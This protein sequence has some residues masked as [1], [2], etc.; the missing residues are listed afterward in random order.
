MLKLN[1]LITDN[2][3]LQ[4]EKEILISGHAQPNVVVII[5]IENNKTVGKTDTEG[6]FLIKLPPQKYGLISKLKVTAATDTLEVAVQ[7]GDVFLFSGQSNIE[8]LMTNE[9]HFSDEKQKLGLEQCGIYFKNV[10]QIEYED[11]QER[12]PNLDWQPWQ[13]VTENNL[14]QLSAIAYYAAA[15]YQRNYPN[16]IIGVVC[17]CKG[18]TSAS[19]WISER[20]LS[21]SQRISEEILLP[22]KKKI[23]GRK[24]ADFDSE[25]KEY[26]FRASAY[27]SKREKW[28]LEHPELSLGKI[29][30]IIGG[31]PW[32]PPA[33]PYL[34]TRP[35][36]LYQTMFK[37]IAPFTF[38]SVIWYQ[39]EEDTAAGHLY[40]ELLPLLIKQWR[41][42][43]QEEIPFYIVQLPTCQDKPNHDWPAVRAAQQKATE[44]FSK[45]FLVTSLD[46][47]LVDNI[48]PPEKSVLGK[49]IGEILTQQYYSTA[50][51][52]KLISWEKEEVIIEISQAA[53][54]SLISVG[55]IV[56]DQSTT[57]VTL[58][59]NKI[60]IEASEP[61][62]EVTYAW[63]NAPQEL[64]FNEVGYPVSP[65]KFERKDFVDGLV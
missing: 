26:S 8:F 7:Y 5:E 50:P 30:E 15:E 45:V 56:V 54:L 48:H 63:C 47:G 33:N 10:P 11:L 16:R 35:C 36:G 58:S 19:A 9:L 53:Q 14:E 59:D 1:P 37:K 62:S 32:P 44:E 18:G 17:C 64:L 2:V 34:F 51:I 60:I 20:Y 13:Q 24:R 21:Q 4:A 40:E 57:K 65:F 46:C 41:C 42:D 39:G 49:R 12:I 28:V 55:T 27:Y 29:K 3:V 31:S 43:L 23:A 22:Y 52:A 38:Q 6:A 25:F 61:L